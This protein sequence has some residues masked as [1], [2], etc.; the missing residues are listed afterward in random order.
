MSPEIKIE[1]V[2]NSDFSKISLSNYDHVPVKTQYS[3][4]PIYKN[5]NYNSVET[6]EPVLNF[7][8]FEDDLWLISYPKCGT[9]WSQEMVWCLMNNMDFE[10]S[11]KVDIAEK[12]PYLE[13]TLDVVEKCK[14]LPRP[15][16]ITSHEEMQLLP[17][18]LWTKRPKIIFVV[19]DPRDVFVSFH[20]HYKYFYGKSFTQDRE[21][22]IE[23]R[24]KYGNFYELVLNFYSLKNQEN[25]VL[26]LSYEQ[27][28]KNL[29]SVVLKVSDFLGK[30]YNEVQIDKLVE[31]LD[32]K[33]M[34]NNPSCSH[35]KELE[36][37]RKVKNIKEEDIVEG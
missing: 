22:F 37:V 25:N 18:E 2:E 28:K 9:T 20:H 5:L 3:S 1:A 13:W 29:K 31:H 36:L 19:R 4:K 26:F 8:V 34:K 21:T 12:S 24:M 30:H 17:K 32:F 33:N 27:M 15:R 11:K 14:G 10:T 6:L 16:F 35:K 7:E 23:G